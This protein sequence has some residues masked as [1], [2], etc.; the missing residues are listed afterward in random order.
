MIKLQCMKLKPKK[1][2]LSLAIVLLLAWFGYLNYSKAKTDKFEA[3]RTDAPSVQFRITKDNTLTAVVGNL[4]YYD[5]IK[6]EEAFKYALEHTEDNN[7]GRE[8]A[9]QVGNNTIDT[10]AVYSIS[11]AMDAWELARVLLN[12]G[13]LSTC[14]HGCPDSLFQPEL[15]PGGDPAPT[16]EEQYQWV[17]TYEDCV[18]AKGQLS[19]EQYYERT[20]IRTCVT[21]DR[22]EFT[23]G[24]E[25]WAEFV[26][27]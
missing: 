10:Q 14:D 15:L 4:K 13:T 20:G 22:R 17:K 21:P 6:D 19:S 12:E 8:G 7:P 26:G 3:P 27:G 23:E 9:I 18:E 16:T 1:L 2:L 5:F 25:G 11:Q 24:Q